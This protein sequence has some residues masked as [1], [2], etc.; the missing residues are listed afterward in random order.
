MVKCYLVKSL[1]GI[2]RDVIDGVG[3]CENWKRTVIY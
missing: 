2:A 1:F 3:E